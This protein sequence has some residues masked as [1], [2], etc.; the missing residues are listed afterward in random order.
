[1]PKP[2]LV[3]PDTLFLPEEGR[4]RIVCGI[5]LVEWD[6][7]VVYVHDRKDPFGLPT[8]LYFQVRGTG[9]YRLDEITK[10][11]D[12]WTFYRGACWR[13][14]NEDEHEFKRAKQMAWRAV[15]TYRR[16]YLKKHGTEPNPLILTGTLD[17]D[18]ARKRTRTVG[19]RKFGDT[20]DQLRLQFESQT[21]S[22]PAAF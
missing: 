10:I 20:F 14:F 4:E 2:K 8:H 3:P 21:T 11:V 1:M 13:T 16:N 19:R 12:Q 17:D 15:A 18:L 5:T 7:V 6:Y 22:S 9:D